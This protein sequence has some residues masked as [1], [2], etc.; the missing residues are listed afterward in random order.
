MSQLPQELL[1][2]IACPVCKGK[3]KL[4]DN[5]LC[6]PFDQLAFPIHDG[7]PVLI[8]EEARSISDSGVQ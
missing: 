3:L 6:C 8:A 7:I 4:V 1:D 5:E 2:I